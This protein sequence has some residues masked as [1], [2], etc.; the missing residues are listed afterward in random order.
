MGM[1]QVRVQNIKTGKHYVLTGPEWELLKKKGYGSLFTIIDE[2]TF[3]QDP[4]ATMIPEEIS[5]AATAA[6]TTL[7][8]ITDQPGASRPDT[9]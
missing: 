7:K 3:V 6:Q 9:L 4:V 2:R 8:R 5:E 1:L